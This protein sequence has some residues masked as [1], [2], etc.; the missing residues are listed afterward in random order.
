MYYLLKAKLFELLKKGDNFKENPALT[1]TEDP[2]I[3]NRIKPKSAKTGPKSAM[4]VWNDIIKMP[5]EVLEAD[6]L[7]DR[8]RAC[9][10][11]SFVDPS[12]PPD[13]SS[14]YDITN[15]SEYPLEE[16]AVWKR[17]HQFMRFGEIELFE[18]DINPNDII[19]GYLGNCWFLAA[20]AAVAE[21]PELI[22]RLFITD[23]YN[24]FGIYKLRICKNGEWVV[25]TIDDYFPCYLD[26]GP[27]FSQPNGNELWLILV[28]KAYAKL[29]GNYNQLNLGFI[30]HAMM[31]LSGCPTQCYNFP[32]KKASSTEKRVFFENLWRIM[33]TSWKKGHTICAGT[34]GVDEATMGNRPDEKFGIVPGHAYSVLKVQQYKDIQLIK[35]RNPWGNF[36]WGGAWSDVD[37]RWTEELRR[38]FKPDFNIND[39]IFWMSY[40]DFIE[41]YDQVM[42]CKVENWNEVRLKGKFIKVQEMSST[43]DWIL[44][45]FYY[46]FSLSQST[47]LEIGIHQEDERILGAER[48]PYIDLSYVILKRER[49]GE[50]KVAGIADN[51]SERDVEQG[52][53]L[54]E[55]D[56]I[57]V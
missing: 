4:K 8:I 37:K 2:I 21:T 49:S 45:Q 3:V 16:K 31:D 54:T 15:A 9:G 7:E 11:D 47:H 24:E 41:R 32:D 26:G 36:E 18:G 53:E 10:H 13:D 39:G 19:Q 40:K 25:V 6:D 23:K 50:L 1:I 34:P 51:V 30:N 43:N 55:G 17:P 35:L 44:S 48:R 28:E 46:T 56:Y 27:V 20:I 52:F 14:L 42:V 38:V 33:D 57:V 29:H 22:R 12:F 5:F